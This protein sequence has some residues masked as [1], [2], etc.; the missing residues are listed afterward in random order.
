M[1][2]QSTTINDPGSHGPDAGE[3]SPILLL[4]E[5]TVFLGELAR[6]ATNT[7]VQLFGVRNVSHDIRNSIHSMKHV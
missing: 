1:G 6:K 4:Q 3:N 5:D 7:K 2:I